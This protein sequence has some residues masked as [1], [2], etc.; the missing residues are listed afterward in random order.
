M[1]GWI[2]KK[3]K[4]LYNVE[5]DPVPAT[6]PPVPDHWLLGI[7]SDR[8]PSP[9]QSVLVTKLYSYISTTIYKLVEASVS[10]DSPPE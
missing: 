5:L 2:K 1:D 8:R 7:I 6:V 4:G 9:W 3:K 10:T